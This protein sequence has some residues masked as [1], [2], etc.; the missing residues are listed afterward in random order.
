MRNTS[1]YATQLLFDRKSF[2]FSPS[3]ILF[4]WKSPKLNFMSF[5]ALLR[6]K[7]KAEVENVR[8]YTLTVHVD[9]Q[10]LI[11]PNVSL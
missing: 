1:S 4:Y 11:P 10:T 9:A 3:C 8:L 6:G 2:S 7:R 5:I